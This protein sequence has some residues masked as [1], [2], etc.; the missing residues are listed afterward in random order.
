MHLLIYKLQWLSLQLIV[1]ALPRVKNKN[2][3]CRGRGAQLRLTCMTS[4]CLCLLQWFCRPALWSSTQ[5][6]SSTEQFF[7]LITSSTGATGSAGEPP[8]S[9][10]AEGSFSAYGRTYTRMLCTDFL[11][12][13]HRW[14]VHTGTHT[15]FPHTGDVLLIFTLWAQTQFL[16]FCCCHALSVIFRQV[17]KA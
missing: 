3:N 1:S 9:C 10:W 6:S 14:T 11:D 15:H 8:S 13:P 12:N 7:R 5:S 17:A 16:S 2:E 4:Y